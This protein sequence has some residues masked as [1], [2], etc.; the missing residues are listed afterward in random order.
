MQRFLK[1]L[2]DFKNQDGFYVFGSTIAGK[3]LNFLLSF[4]VI[5]ILS[6]ESYG[7]AIYAVNAIAFIMPFAGFGAYTGVLRFGALLHSEDEKRELFQHA[8][9]KGLLFSSLL[10]LLFWILSPYIGSDFEDSSLFIKIVS[11]QVISFT[12][13]ELVKSYV[14]IIH[15]NKLFAGMDFSLFVIQFVLGITL[16]YYLHGKGYLIAL[17]SSPLLAGFYYFF[18]LKLF[19][20]P[21]LPHS[22]QQASFWSYSIYTS[23]GGLASQ[24]LF[25]ID[26]FLIGYL[27]VDAEQVAYYKAATLIPF[28]LSFI[29]LAYIHT[30]FVNVSKNSD[31]KQWLLQYLKGYYSIFIPVGIALTGTLFLAG[32]FIFSFLKPEYLN[33]VP[34][35]KVLLIGIFGSFLFRVPFGNLLPAIGKAKWNTAVSIII[36]SINLPANYF[37]IKHYGIIGA[38]Y[39]T[40][41][42]MWLSGIINLILFL[43]WKKR[44]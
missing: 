36:L 29:P 21:Q 38:A 3:S 1:T 2:N 41:F 32:D 24:L 9:K 43:I 15:Q 33:S 27:L 16:S 31:N 34:P 22:T 20:K 39:T 11:F 30:T 4:I 10:I 8:L 35:Y 19:R 28:N 7:Q 23:I 12:F 37:A 44:D 18:K 17:V 25:L 26:I 13:F 40:T 5:E 42:L 14:R 6:A